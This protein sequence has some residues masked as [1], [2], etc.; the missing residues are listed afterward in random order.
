MRVKKIK[1]ALVSVIL[2]VCM[3]VNILGCDKNISAKNLM[4]HAL[5]AISTVVNEA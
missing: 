5:A 4:R 1:L 2:L 3:G